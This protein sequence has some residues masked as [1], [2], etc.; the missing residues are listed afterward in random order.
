MRYEGRGLSCGGLFYFEN[1]GDY[2]DDFF[3]VVEEGVFVVDEVGGDDFY[4]FVLF[5]FGGD[6]VNA[7]EFAFI[8]VGV[9]DMV[10]D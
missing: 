6:V 1:F 5:G 3:G 9:N 10:I 7:A 4:V 2:L 8:A